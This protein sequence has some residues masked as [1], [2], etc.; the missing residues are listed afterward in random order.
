MEKGKTQLKNLVG[1]TCEDQKNR[2]Q[3]GSTFHVF[4]LAFDHPQIQLCCVVDLRRW[5]CNLTVRCFKYKNNMGP[6]E[7]KK[8]SALK[9][10]N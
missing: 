6:F 9:P 10:S 8:L 7:Q 2:Y 3:V 4:V 1:S 5:T